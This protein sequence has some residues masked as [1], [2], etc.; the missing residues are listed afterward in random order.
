MHFHTAIGLILG[1]VVCCS[2]TTSSLSESF[3]PRDMVTNIKSSPAVD[4][5]LT[6]TESL[7]VATRALP[8]ADLPS[9]DDRPQ[10]V[11]EGQRPVKG[12]ADDEEEKQPPKSTHNIHKR[13]LNEQLILEHRMMNYSGCDTCRKMHLDMKQASLDHIKN[14]VLT[15]LGFNVS[16]PPNRRSTYPP[17]PETILEQ[18]YRNSFSPGDDWE[19]E[20]INQ[21]NQQR[22]LDMQAP[23]VSFE[24]DYMADDPNWNL[25]QQPIAEDR[26]FKPIVTTNRIYLFA[27]GEL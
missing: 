11:D 10:H 7:S 13:D 27:N 17:V 9:Y 21:Q 25:R 14:Y 16:G 12:E 22:Y 20:R 19:E 5:L 15:V 8:A 26:P 24:N 3:E 18:Y 1:L 2:S 23:G 6:T 4:L